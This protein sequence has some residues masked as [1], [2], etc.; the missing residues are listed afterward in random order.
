MII[1]LSLLPFQLRPP[2][3]RGQRDGARDVGGDA[4][5]LLQA[6]AGTR[7]GGGQRRHRRRSR[8]LHQRLPPRHRVRQLLF[9]A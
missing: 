2:L 5:F 8:P 1:N 3:R 9:S 4:V 7:G 6:A